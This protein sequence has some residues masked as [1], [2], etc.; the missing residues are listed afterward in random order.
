MDELDRKLARL[1]RRVQAREREFR[2]RL[3]TAPELVALLEGLKAAF[4]PLRLTHVQIG[5]WS[6]GEP[7]QRGIVPAPYHRPTFARRGK[8]EA[9]R[10]R[11]K[12]G[13]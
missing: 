5:D 11:E 7:P 4:G 8:A 12:A 10:A 9:L 13:R 1:D 6:H 2:Q 3:E